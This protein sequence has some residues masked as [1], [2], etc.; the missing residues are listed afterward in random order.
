MQGGSNWRYTKWNEEAAWPRA[1]LHHDL[2]FAEEATDYL[3]AR[4]LF[5]TRLDPDAEAPDL[6]I[7]RVELEV[8]EGPRAAPSPS[9]GSDATRERCPRQ[10]G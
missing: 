9:R 1:V 10:W 2:H 8:T 4:D 7:E 5:A 6:N 3:D